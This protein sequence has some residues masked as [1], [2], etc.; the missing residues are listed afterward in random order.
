MSGY[1]LKA[2]LEQRRRD[3]E[4]AAL[5]LTSAA[6]QREEAEAQGLRK[7]AE[8]AAAGERLRRAH[9]GAQNP[10]R[11]PGDSRAEHVGEP[12]GERRFATSTGAEAA[13]SARFVARLRDDLARAQAARAAFQ[14]GP[15]REARDAEI[16]ARGD[17][18]AA[19]QGREALDKHEA[20]FQ[21][22]VRRAAERRHEDALED[23]AR[24]ARHLRNARD[25]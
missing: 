20:R 4:A 12:G 3:E 19:R 6:R 25:S 15:L 14:A 17:H 1:P 10:S 5:R 24:A 23:A 11:A 18:V 9:A 2:V 13:A 21:D 8:V 16:G 7:D 22:S